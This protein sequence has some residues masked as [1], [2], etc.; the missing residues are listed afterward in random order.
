MS[1]NYLYIEVNYNMNNF[2]CKI[3]GKGYPLLLSLSKHL[4]NKH[5][6][7]GGLIQYYVDYEKFKIPKCIYCDCDAKREEGLKFIKTCGN[8]TC[9]TKLKKTKFH[10][11]ESKMKIRNKMIAAYKSGKQTGWAFINKDINRR[12]YP[13]KWFIKNVIEKYNLNSKYTIKE[14]FSFGKYFLDF[15]IIDMKIDLEI[16]GQQHFRTDEAIEHDKERDKFVSDNDWKVYRIAWIEL[17]NDRE[18]VIKNFLEWLD[19]N[20]KECRKY[21]VNFLLKTL[22]KTKYD[23]QK[24]YFLNRKERYNLRQIPLIKK[25]IS[26]DIDFSKE[27][28]G[29]KVSIIVGISENKGSVWMKR[30]MNDF[31][32]NKCWKR[33]S[34][35]KKVL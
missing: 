12:S 34:P 24:D 11:E 33:K 25:I 32:I 7:K 22:K 18:I 10:T 30:N 23:S 3:C 31:F 2:N 9:V 17:K 27:G 5:K 28:W 4:T 14:K 16:D 6:Y 1:F 19:S 20:D 35:T 8:K 29:K 21:D 15:A 13:E 26:S